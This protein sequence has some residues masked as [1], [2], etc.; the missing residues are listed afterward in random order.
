M[1]CATSFNV[2]VALSSLK[3]ESCFLLESSII[4]EVAFV[5]I[6]TVVESSN[7]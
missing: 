3:I 4:N 7:E 1:E 5:L 6:L 2:T